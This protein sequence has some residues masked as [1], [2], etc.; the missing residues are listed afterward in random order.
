VNVL[1]VSQEYPPE[2]G[3]G[4]IATHT[5]R[6]AHGLAAL[7]H[8][9]TVLSHAGAAGPGERRDGEV[10]V[11]RIA[12]ADARL[13]VRTEPARW[14]CWS[15]AVAA[16]VDGLLQREPFDVVE[17][18]EWGAEGFVWLLNRGERRGPVAIVHLQGPLC[19]FVRELDWPAPDDELRRIGIAMEGACLRLADAVLSSSRYSARACADA[20]A[21]DGDA[22]PVVHA[23][24]DLQRFRPRDPVA[25]PAT[26]PLV[27][28]VGRVAASKGADVLVDAALRVA[29]EFPGLRVRLI[30]R[31]DDGLGGRL[32]ARAAAAGL[33]DLLELP[34]PVP[35][36]AL[37]AEYHAATVFCAPSPCEGGPGFVQ[38]EAMASGLPVIGCAETGVAEVIEHGVTGLLVPRRDPTAL[39]T[40]LRE[41]LG[42]AARA[43]ALGRAA[44]A[45][46]ERD[47]DPARCAARLVSLYADACAD[48]LRP[49]APR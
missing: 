10:R 23:G 9:V 13:A 31:D 47:A 14:L 19:M 5:H 2:T 40:A 44:R 33:P 15:A 4:G 34:G 37:P 30:G 17:F 18:V 3:H 42:D 45:H 39:A 21:L 36:T 49:A 38:L 6:K 24:V 25:A 1:L 12:G 29:A 43:A 35:H 26:R 41:L 8:R 11:V 20:Y 22:I 46:V 27:L 48:R 32:T 7:G 28:F 16:A